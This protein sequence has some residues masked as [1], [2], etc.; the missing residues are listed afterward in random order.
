[1]KFWNNQSDC[2]GRANKSRGPLL[3]VHYPMRF[4]SPPSLTCSREEASLN[5]TSEAVAGSL[6]DCDFVTIPLIPGRI[7]FE[8][9]Y[10]L[11]VVAVETPESILKGTLAK[12]IS[13]EG[14]GV[15]H[16]TTSSSALEPL[17][18]DVLRQVALGATLTVALRAGG[19]GEP[20]ITTRRRDHDLA[21]DTLTLGAST[22][23]RRRSSSRDEER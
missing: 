14:K 20:V 21:N 10:E 19:R 18:G 3:R 11:S 15:P 22:T 4:A 9:N 17:T 12:P 6:S 8:M 13:I 16:A 1:M 5:A 7:Q 2:F 23:N